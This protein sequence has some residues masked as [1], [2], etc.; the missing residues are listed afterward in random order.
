MVVKITSLV[1][2]IYLS[3]VSHGFRCGHTKGLTDRRTQIKYQLNFKTLF[4]KTIK[5]K[6]Y[7]K[8]IRTVCIRLSP[9]YPW[10][11]PH[12]SFVLGLILKFWVTI[13]KSNTVSTISTGPQARRIICQVLWVNFL[14]HG[15][16]MR[17]GTK[18]CIINSGVDSN[19]VN[20][21]PYFKMCESFITKFN[22]LHF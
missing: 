20:T 1:S 16:N 17:A 21:C 11:W 15:M 18:S 5:F 7:Q 6:K 2:K 3:S 22:M 4:T 19:T 9:T 8:V 14:Q 12:S 13:W 10:N